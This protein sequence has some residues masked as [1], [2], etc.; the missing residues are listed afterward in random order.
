MSKETFE[1]TGVFSWGYDP[2]E[3]DAFLEQAKESYSNPQ[4]GG[5]DEQAVR[6]VAFGRKRRGYRP[7][8]VDS[9]LD[10]LETAFIQARRADT[11]QSDGENAWLNETYENAKS[12]YPR[13]IRPATERFADAEGLGYDKADV[14]QLMD[15]L[16]NYFDGK[17]SLASDDVRSV[18]FNSAKKTN[19]Y[20]AAVVDVYLE[21]VVTVLV[22]V[23]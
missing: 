16:A 22:A 1:R 21:R 19:A 4:P 12:L 18:T 6:N 23:E 10:R 8:L 9:A 7:E 14:D 2:E 3:V 5:T 15:R 13:L 11:V 17:E 20:D